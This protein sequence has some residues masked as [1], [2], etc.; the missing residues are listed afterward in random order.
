MK[1]LITSTLLFL[2]VAPL[3]QAHQ[4]HSY[5]DTSVHS[6]GEFKAK[7]V[8]STPVYKYVIVRQPQTYCEPL[9]YKTYGHSYDR[10]SY[11]RQ[12]YDRQ[13][14]DRQ[15][16]DN[17]SA[18]IAGGILGG[19]IGHVASD[20]RHEG[21][22]T[23]VGAVIGSSLVHNIDR[24]NKKH[25]RTYQVQPKNCVVTHKK[26]RKVRVLDGYKVTYRSHGKLYRTFRK[27]KPSRYIRVLY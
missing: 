9:V 15:S 4:D 3:S 21:L 8:N 23:I 14:Y 7:V 13:S 1:L 17:K 25:L 22:G 24:T 2:T 19:L 16:Y 26:N 12:S 5:H 27:N 10:Q 18:A 20:R 6:R 11:D